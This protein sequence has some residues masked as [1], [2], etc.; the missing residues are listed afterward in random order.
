MYIYMDIKYVSLYQIFVTF[1][2]LPS[3]VWSNIVENFS[4]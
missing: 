2:N 3:I 1:S 4:L